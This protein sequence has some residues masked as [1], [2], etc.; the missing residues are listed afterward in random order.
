MTPEDL[1]V[2]ALPALTRDWHSLPDGRRREVVGLVFAPELLNERGPNE[3]TAFLLPREVIRQ[4]LL[5][6]CQEARNT[7]PLDMVDANI[8]SH[9]Q[10]V[11]V[12]FAPRVVATYFL[13]HGGELDVN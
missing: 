13:R 8:S 7:R 5:A 9:E 12:V 3:R 10:L 11:I 1:L 2:D 6:A 4:G